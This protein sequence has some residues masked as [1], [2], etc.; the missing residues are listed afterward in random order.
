MKVGDK[1]KTFMGTGKIRSIDDKKSIVNVQYRNLLGE[2]I[3]VPFNFKGLMS[4][5]QRR[6]WRCQY[7][8]AE[9]RIGEY[10][11]K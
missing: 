2:K 5:V 6:R 3:T 11:R 4:L 10:Q 1:I 7:V 8:A 9:L